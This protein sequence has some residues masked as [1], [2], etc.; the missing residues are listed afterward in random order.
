MKA[1]YLQGAGAEVQQ[2]VKSTSDHSNRNDQSSYAQ[3]D[4][5]TLSSAQLFPC[6][7]HGEVPFKRGGGQ[8]PKC[9]ALQHAQ[10]MRV[11][12]KSIGAKTLL[13]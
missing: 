9:E 3:A 10:N 13:P 6:E 4:E 5:D 8:G 2:D 1:G 7:F 12:T 11:Y